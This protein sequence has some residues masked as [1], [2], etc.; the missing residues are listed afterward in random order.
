MRLSLR[1]FVGPGILLLIS[2]SFL[3]VFSVMSSPYT[4]AAWSWHITFTLH[5]NELYPGINGY[6]EAWIKNTGDCELYI[7]KVWLQWEWQV[8]DNEAYSISVDV[9]LDP[10]EEK[11]LGK[12]GFSIP[13]DLK[14]GYYGIRFGVSQMHKTWL[15]WVNDGLVWASN[16][17]EERILSAPKIEIIFCDFES[18]TVKQGDTVKLIIQI[19]NLGEATAR[20]VEVRVSNPS[21]LSLQSPSTE[22][23]GDIMGRSIE[24]VSFT[25]V[26]E[27]PGTYTVTVIVMSNNAGSDSAS[28][29]IT[30]EANP[31]G[32]S[33]S[34]SSSSLLWISIPTILA[35]ITGV[36]LLR[37]K[38][39]PS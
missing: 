27:E 8:D 23:V 11:Y 30:V 34:K 21:G 28:A 15:G 1:N 22:F 17:V 20:G 10:G 2:A 38:H 36:T 7:Y 6:A 29:T 32:I 3:S 25:F 12:I 9:Y 24:E 37:R 14:P 33:L 19:K 13:P 18:T 26:A 16:W 35:L 31:L 5:P 39:S 4:P